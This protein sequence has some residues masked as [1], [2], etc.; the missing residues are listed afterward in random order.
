[1]SAVAT[2]FTPLTGATT[3]FERAF[4]TSFVIVRR[5]GGAG[6]QLRA[7]DYTI[8]GALATDV[9][10]DIKTIFGMLGLPLPERRPIVS[11]TTP[12][13]VA[14]VTPSDGCRVRKN[15]CHS[16]QPDES[17]VDYSRMALC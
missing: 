5:K 14:R 11:E 3:S 13:T 2:P 4:L 6:L 7:K 8:P 9:T 16:M 12:A 15:R 1:M 17:T 10:T